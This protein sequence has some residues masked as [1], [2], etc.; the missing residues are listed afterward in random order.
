M[1]LGNFL[2]GCDNE[3]EGKTLTLMDL[4]EDVTIDILMRLPVK[5][6]CCLECVSKTSLNSPQF[7]APLTRRLYNLSSAVEV[8]QLMLLAQYSTGLH[9]AINLQSLKYNGSNCS[10]KTNFA[11]LVFTDYFYNYDVEFVFGNL[12]GISRRRMV[13]K[14]LC[15]L[16]NPLRGEVLKLPVSDVKVPISNSFDLCNYDRYGMGFDHVSRTYKIVHISRNAPRRNTM[17]EYARV[18]AT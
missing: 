10:T 16:V 12:F 5:S 1:E 3:K 13:R 18:P 7:A 14:E 6:L 2:K 15:Y 4:P 9:R 11:D 8:P 17:T